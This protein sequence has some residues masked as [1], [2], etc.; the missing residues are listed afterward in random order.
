MS[1][2]KAKSNKKLRLA[3]LVIQP[4]LVWD[5]GVE[6]TSG[7][8]LNSVQVSISQAQHFLATLPAEVEILEQQLAES[9][10]SNKLT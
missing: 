8:D 10:K 3:H 9:L 6:I 2:N 7:P 5:D 1:D 4:V